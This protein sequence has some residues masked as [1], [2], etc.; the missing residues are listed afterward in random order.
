MEE[1]NMV[2]PLFEKYI[3]TPTASD[4][5]EVVFATGRSTRPYSRSY[6]S[7][8]KRIDQNILKAVPD[9]DHNK[10]SKTEADTNTMALDEYSRKLDEAV[11]MCKRRK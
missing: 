2:S 3:S 4:R 6:V 7:D 8:N 11:A 9:L 5:D 10:E 1:F